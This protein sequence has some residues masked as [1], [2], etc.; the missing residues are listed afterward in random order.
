MVVEPFDTAKSTS[1]KRSSTVRPSR[2]S[3]VSKSG[4]YP[5]MKGEFHAPGHNFTGPGT[6]FRKRQSMGIR[7]TGAVDTV[8]YYHDMSYSMIGRARPT[9][10]FIAAR[11]GHPLAAVISV[12]AQYGKGASDIGSGFA[13]YGAAVKDAYTGSYADFG[14]GVAGGTGLVLGGLVRFSNPVL[15]ATTDWLG[16]T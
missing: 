7:P 13:M 5:A 4:H 1:V 16:W 11:L 8:S 15:T 12:G 3:R 14:Y 6:R 10:T 9:G 2:R